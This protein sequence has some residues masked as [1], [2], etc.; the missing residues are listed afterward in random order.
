MKDLTTGK[1][2]SGDLKRKMKKYYQ[3]QIKK[4]PDVAIVNIK[5]KVAKKFNIKFVE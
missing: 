2:I 5:E 3:H 1:E 4:H